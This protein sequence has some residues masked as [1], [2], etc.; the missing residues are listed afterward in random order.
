MSSE[1]ERVCALD[2]DLV[3]ASLP[4]R[5]DLTRAQLLSRLAA[6]ATASLCSPVA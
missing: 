6:E 3:A 4:S 1:H 5:L 2:S